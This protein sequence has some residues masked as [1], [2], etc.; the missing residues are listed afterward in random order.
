MLSSMAS[1]VWC[2]FASSLTLAAPNTELYEQTQ[3]RSSSV[4]NTQASPSSIS[5]LEG[6]SA[7]SAISSSAISSRPVAPSL[8]FSRTIAP[9]PTGVPA[10]KN[11]K[12]G[13]A[14][15]AAD[16]P[17]DI[18]NANQTSSVVSWQ[19]NWA[20]IPP[21]YLA[22]SN[23]PFIPMQWGSGSIEG[24]SDAVRS[25][26]ADVVLVRFYYFINGAKYILIKPSSGIQ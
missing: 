24:F 25:Q 15:A 26:G 10:R 9:R 14:F 2:L 18:Y 6:S 8:S 13:L 1:L 20:N 4:T 17:I 7:S 12:R 19:Y 23:I 3:P 21:A 5:S 16:S 22:T 11:P